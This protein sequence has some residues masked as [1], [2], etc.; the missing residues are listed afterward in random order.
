MLVLT[1]EFN[2]DQ[3]QK[4]SFMAV[5]GLSIALPFIILLILNPTFSLIDTSKHFFFVPRIPSGTNPDAAPFVR[6]SNWLSNHIWR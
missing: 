1:T 5:A 2:F 3:W 4:P 6:P